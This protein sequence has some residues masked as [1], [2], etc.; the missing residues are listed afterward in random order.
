MFDDT[1]G[2]VHYISVPAPLILGS[3]PP[4]RV[5]PA[6]DLVGAVVSADDLI[7]FFTSAA[8]VYCLIDILLHGTTLAVTDRDTDR[9]SQRIGKS[10]CI[11]FKFLEPGN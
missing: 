8:S 10:S 11:Y 2:R 6:E 9:R 1:R 7:F 5:V 3:G 4:C